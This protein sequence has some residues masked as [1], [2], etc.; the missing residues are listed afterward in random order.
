MEGKRLLSI[1]ALAAS[2]IGT[3]VQAQD[4]A[5]LKVGIT[6]SN[7]G[8]F[9]L[10]SQSGERGVRI[11]VD[12]VNR[13]GGI[14]F[15]GEKRKLE[16]VEL[17]DRSDKQMVPR[18]YETM[19]TN[20]NV[21]V[22]IAPFGST[23]T[24]VAATV[25]ERNNK[26][27]ISWSASS[28]SIYEQGYKNIVSAVVPS[29]LIPGTNLR[30]LKEAGVKKIAIAYVDEAF[31][32]SLAEAAYKE[33]TKMGFDVVMNETYQKGTKDFSVI[34]Q[35]AQA[36]GAE[37]FYPHSYEVDSILM[38]KQMKELDIHFANVYMMYG[39]TPQ[40]LEL[41]AAADYITSHTQYNPAVKW[42]ITDGL[43]NDAFVA[44]Y[45]ELFPK[46]SYSEDFQT[47]LAYGAGVALER[48]LGEAKSTEPAKLKQAALDLS[49]KI[50]TI[51]GK[52]AIDET[53][54][55]IGMEPIVLQN[56]PGK[57][58]VPVAPPEVATEK[59]IYPIPQ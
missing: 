59:L 55:Q 30:L 16:L 14:D 5:P 57:G 1:A 12:D 43:Q 23:L 22:L 36:L 38:V 42:A 19:I 39:S 4:A 45:K 51:S 15:N 3:G 20:D 17:D 25:A 10:A 41:G 33:A 52:F 35:K 18:V 54:K 31:P 9:M 7:S 27:M 46:V 6:V 24:G 13:R 44:R 21:D 53:G 32:A 2:L 50:T 49:G 58:L 8:T 11:W 29:S 37:A 26:F 47:V 56:Q 28:D 48:L 34:L 40:F